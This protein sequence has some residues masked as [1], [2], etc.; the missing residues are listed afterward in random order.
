MSKACE[1]CPLHEYAQTNC[2]AGD[3]PKTAKVCYALQT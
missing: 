3:G 1:L 2:M